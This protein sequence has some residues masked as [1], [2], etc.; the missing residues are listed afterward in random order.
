MRL[1]T[2]LLDKSEDIY[3]MKGL[4]SVQ[5]MKERF[6]FQGGIYPKATAVG[7]DDVDHFIR[8]VL[9]D[10]LRNRVFIVDKVGDN[11]RGIASNCG[12]YATPSSAALIVASIPSIGVSYDLT[13]LMYTPLANFV[14]TL[15]RLLTTLFATDFCTINA[16]QEIKLARVV[17]GL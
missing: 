17:V 8:N 5:G 6:I 10:D 16:V 15:V 11:A 12:S 2:L 7:A 9:K 14:D 4:L 3:R 1:G 13:T